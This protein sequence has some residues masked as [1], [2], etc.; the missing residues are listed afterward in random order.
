M[1]ATIPINADASLVPTPVAVRR[2]SPAMARAFRI[3]TVGLG[4]CCGALAYAAPY[5]SSDQLRHAIGEIAVVL[6]SERMDVTILDA[7]KEGIKL[8]LMAAGL[9]LDDGVC[10][11]YYNASPE[12]GLTQ[13]FAPVTASDMPVWLNAI[14]AHEV[15]HCIEQREA[16]IRRRFD[17][18]LPP[19]FK[20]ENVTV[21]GYYSVVKS[22]AVETWGEALADIVSVLYFKQTVPE[23]W[24]QFATKLAVMRSDQTGGRPEHNTS[25]W[26]KNLIA[27]GADTPAHLSLFEAAF[28][29]RRQLQP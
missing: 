28:Q 29:L 21:Q 11:V 8:T 22:G 1:L 7:Q 2:V 23:R 27:F 13:F 16:Y 10:L 4:L 5:P 6:K 19:G 26:L 3:A 20:H 12:D 15:T 18:V 24:E 25:L 17:L 9:R 14:A